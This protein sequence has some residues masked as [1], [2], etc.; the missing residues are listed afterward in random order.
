MKDSN[1]SSDTSRTFLAI[2]RSDVSQSRG[3]VLGDSYYVIKKQ[4]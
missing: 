4:V 1:V 2:L 3:F